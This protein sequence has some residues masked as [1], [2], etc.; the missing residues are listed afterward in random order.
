MVVVTRNRDKDLSLCLKSLFDQS[1][2]ADE[3]VVVDNESKIAIK[4]TFVRRF[5]KVKFVRSDVNLG[6]AGGRNLGLLHTK[7]KYILFMDD[8]AIADKD[9]ILN[10]FLEVKR[11]KK[12]GI[13]Q[14]KIYEKER[15]HTIQGV[16]H[17]INLRTGRVYGIGV[18]EKDIGQYEEV[19]EIPM[20][21][22]T[23]MVSRQVFDQIGNYD[24]DFFIPYEDSDFS[25]RTTKA[26]FKILYIPKANVWHTGAKSTF[27]HPWIEWLGITS[28]ERSYRVSRNKIIFMKKHASTW[29]F[30]VFMA[31]YEP[32]YA[33]LH[34]TIILLAGRTDILSNYWKGLLSGIDYSLF[35]LKLR[36]LSWA[37]PV[38]WIIDRSAKNILDV[39]CGRGLPMMVLKQ[40]M[41]FQRIEGV[42]LYEPYI[43][44]CKRLE[45]H[46]SYMIS[47]V[48][49]LPY[50][51]KSFDVVMALQVL[52]H[53]EKNES[54]KI[55]DKLEKIAKKQVIVSMPIGK[56]YHPPADGNILQLHKS[57]FLP[58]ELKDRGYKVIKM[59]RKEIEGETGLINK[60]N[61]NIW[62]KLIYLL[63]LVINSLSP[64]FQAFANYYMVAYKNIE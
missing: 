58:S 50:K 5:P 27:V 51:N 18:H 8:D 23:W 37:D 12:I 29:N 40:R 31:L 46:D 62:K 33:T 45:I 48:R 55:L 52:E 10:L 57:G 22:C 7:G 34:S 3:V 17:G 25:I 21:G 6:G 49:K 4:K 11:D 19:I 59:G 28:P 16:G 36:L 63:I 35:S 54:L 32:L 60:F 41:K 15:S 64:F 20:A 30:V 56:T 61:N 13:V 53:L 26:G 39:A 42:D 24:E 9:M 2:Q 38:C 43:Y 44:E 1:F 47:D 14:P